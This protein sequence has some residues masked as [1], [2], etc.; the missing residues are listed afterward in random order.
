MATNGISVFD[1]DGHVFEDMAAI[2]KHLPQNW[3]NSA[4]V[5][6]LGLFPGLDHLR[7][8]LAT[9]PPGT[10]IDPG[11]DGWVKFLDASEITGTVLYPTSALAVGRIPDPDYAIGVTR[12]YNDWL[13][14]TYQ[15]DSRIQGVGLIPMQDPDA[16]VEELRRLVTE[17]GMAGGMLPT[18]GLRSDLG[19]REYWPVYAEADR[20]GCSLAAHGGSHIGYGFDHL[21]IPAGVH[22]MGHPFSITVSFVSMLLHGVFDHFPSAR[23][24]FLEA[25][26]GWFL[27]AAERCAGSYHT[28]SP[29]NPRGDYIALRDGEDIDDYIKRQ[30]AEERLYIGVEGDEPTL[31]WAIKSMGAG[32][33]VFSSDYPHEVTLDSIMGEIN[34]VLENEELTHD[35]KSAVLGSNARRLYS[36]EAVPSR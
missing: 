36:R 31:T 15:K 21:S 10:F 9:L 35:E 34:E 19:S 22:A 30:I 27:M 26:V 33:F 16:A 6:T 1:G 4:L 28:L 20:L 24:G 3:S 18:T 25:G 8:G 23:F 17:L 32:G 13:A 2:S 7:H 12:A 5:K 29:M 11:P 14:D